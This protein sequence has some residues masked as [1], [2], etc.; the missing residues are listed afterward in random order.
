MLIN[1]VNLDILILKKSLI[2]LHYK[3]ILLIFQTITTPRKE[4]YRLRS[5]TVIG[6]ALTPDLDTSI[7]YEV[8]EEASPFD[9]IED[10]LLEDANKALLEQIKTSQ[11]RS[12]KINMWFNS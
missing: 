10:T 8:Q 4:R 2:L 3:L 6:E 11:V 7:P 12:N 9:S 5:R 1:C